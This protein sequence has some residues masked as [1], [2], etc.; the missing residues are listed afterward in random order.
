MV[1]VQDPDFRKA[2]ARP[3]SHLLQRSDYNQGSSDNFEASYHKIYYS[4]S[5]FEDSKPIKIVLRNSKLEKM[6]FHK[7]KFK[8]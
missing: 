5:I 4:K 1:K 7:I 3:I 8:F 2:Y 6:R